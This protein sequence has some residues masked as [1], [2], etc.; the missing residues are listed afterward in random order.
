MRTILLITL[1]LATA[2]ARGAEPDERYPAF[3]KEGKVW[4]CLQP[5]DGSICT[6][7]IE[8]D[9]VI[10]GKDYKKV[11]CQDNFEYQDDAQH[12]FAAVREEDYRVYQ[13][14]AGQEQ[15]YLLYDFEPGKEVELRYDWCSRGMARSAGLPCIFLHVRHT[16]FGVQSY[17]LDS[18]E[19]PMP[20]TF[21][22]D[23]IGD[24]NGGP[25]CT[26]HTSREIL[27]CH[28]GD[29][30]IYEHDEFM[31]FERAFEGEAGGLKYCFIQ[32]SHTATIENGNCWD[33]EL[34]IP[35]TVTYA[36]EDYTVNTIE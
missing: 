33:G 7:T 5:A 32:N 24:L 22:L 1:M 18:D 19:Q 17:P 25:F 12:Y 6:Y 30:C 27:T 4:K 13:R 10:G 31:N 23:G 9:T 28:E 15:E 36:G 34:S 14:N 3:V 16:F 11:H 29:N 21:W 20:L 26:G 35:A 8:G 2:V